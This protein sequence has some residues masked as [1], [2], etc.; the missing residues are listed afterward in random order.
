L[1]LGLAFGIVSVF[2]V[3]LVFNDTVIEITLTFTASYLA[4]FVVCTHL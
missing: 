3:G 4:F 2:W 1:A